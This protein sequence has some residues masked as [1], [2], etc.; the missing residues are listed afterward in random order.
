MKY[1]FT[2]KLV[3]INIF[4]RW[5]MNEKSPWIQLLSE[6]VIKSRYIKKKLVAT[7]LKTIAPV[8]NESQYC[9]VEKSNKGFNPFERMAQIKSLLT[10][11]IKEGFEIK[12]IYR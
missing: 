3:F 4:Y 1:K 2:L 9:P 8:I 11:T 12:F 5:M 6:V 10:E 7:H